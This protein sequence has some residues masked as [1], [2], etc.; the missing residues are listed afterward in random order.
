MSA[1]QQPVQRLLH[2]LSDRP[3]DEDQLSFDPYAQTLAEI[4]PT[5]SPIP[6]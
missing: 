5:L 3:A 6:R 2:I 1:D 4:L